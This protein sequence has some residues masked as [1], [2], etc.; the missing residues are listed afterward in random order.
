MNI[1]KLL[2]SQEREI[3]RLRRIAEQITALE[4]ATKALSN[5]ELRAKTEEFKE[6]VRFDHS[7]M[8]PKER[9][10]VQQEK[11]DEIL[12]EAFAV[13]RE[14]SVRTLGL[15]HFDVQLIGGIVLHQGRIAEMKTGEGKT[16]VATLP[17]Y[18]NALT[19]R[20]AH[21]VTVNDYLSKRD[22]RWMG[23]I[24]HLLGMSVGS[25]HGQS[26]ETGESGNSYI[27]DPDYIAE[28]PTQWDYLRPVS[29][30]EA[31]ACDITYGTNHEFGF[32][33]LRD[34]MAFRLEDLV[35]R[36]LH[37]AIV[38]EVDSI[39]IDEARTPLIISGYAFRSSDMYYKMDRV[40]RQLVK[41]VDYTVDEKAKTAILTEEGIRKVER[42]TGCGN[43]SDP[44]NLEINQYINAAIKAHAVYKKDIDYVVRDGQV[45]IV[46]EFTGRLMFGR[47][48]SD[49]LHQ[50]VEAKEGVKIQEENQTLA[51]ITYQNFFRLY[52]KLAGMTGT[53]KTEEEEFRKIYGLDVVEIPTNRPVIRKDLP[54]V[55]YKTEDAKFRGITLEILKTYS[56]EQPAL[57]GT[58][59]IEVSERL[60][61]RL[62][63]ERLQVLAATVILRDILDRGKDLRG[64]PVDIPSEEKN[65]MHAFLNSR[66]EELTLPRLG[67]IAKRVGVDLDMLKPENIDALA[68]VLDI[69]PSGKAKLA[70]AL[71]NGIPHNV[72]NAKYHEMEAQIIAQAGRRGAVTIATNMAGRGVDIILGG[73]PNSDEEDDDCTLEGPP[74][75]PAEITWDFESWK[76]MNPDKFAE[77]SPRALDVIMR[78]GLYIIGTE[79]H[80]SRRIDNQLRGRSGR[81]GD[82]GLSKFF[83]SLEDELWRL[84]GDKSKS[85]LLSGWREDQALDSR[86]LSRM[87]ERA[88]KKVEMHHFDARK[89]VLEYDDVMN[90][91]RETIYSQRRRILEGVNLRPTV[92]GYLEET[93]RN[94]VN[95]FCPEGVP[96]SEWD[97]E[98]LFKHVNDILPLEFYAKPADFRN[99]RREEIED[100][101]LEIVERSYEAKEQEIGPDLM[102]EIER[103]VALDLINRKWID[104]LDAMDFLRE[105]IGLRGYAQR[106]PLIEYKKEAYE[107]FQA[108]LTSLQDDMVRIM[109]RVQ[110]QAPPRRRRPVFENMTEFSAQ[111]PQGMGGSGSPSAQQKAVPVGSRK[112]NKIG[113]NDPCPCG[114]GKK[115]KKCCLG[116]IEGD[117]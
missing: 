58:R 67:K 117:L 65:E 35:Q 45:I 73:S 28:D 84:F 8:D 33:Y 38:D 99:K 86:L 30:A 1:L 107:L 71:K 46:D 92:I 63:S 96:Q 76:Q 19:G 37:Y 94:A 56:R 109:Y 25:I 9:E 70:E 81:Q 62:I 113:R 102:R 17:L 10:R 39:L 60:S 103:H 47:R 104:H 82:P 42:I 18:L 32:D 51:T 112:S 101:L 21:L 20:G 22:A 14:A 40:A 16:L 80:E 34:N 31:Y 106:D 79:R 49:G 111:G 54:D 6:R 66:F 24:Y 61:E 68:T 83:V 64:N 48:W 2:S 115:Y 52:K 4:P 57:V 7:Q 36:E 116:K 11:L 41:D 12:P 69:R 87:I 91:Q 59:S 29:R 13:V 23:P 15:R 5:E 43:L 3:K 27:Y 114:S 50:A 89:H 78:G 108:M 100:M 110:T 26:A 90:V 93:M 97:F 88:Q 77:A 74:L 85:V 53:A 72:L 44:E 98:G 75:D 95:M 105:G 55:I